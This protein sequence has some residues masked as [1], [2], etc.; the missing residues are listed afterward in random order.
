M[1][2]QFDPDFGLVI[3]QARAHGPAGDFT[4]RLALDTGAT[5]STLNWEVAILLGYD[6]AGVPDRVRMTTA[7]G[8][9]WTF[10]PVP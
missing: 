8:Y 5:I 9:S 4:L 10:A 1:I 7:G 3:L 6:P 2:V